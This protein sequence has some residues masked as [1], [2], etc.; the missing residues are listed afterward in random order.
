MS[1]D[2]T[3]ASVET[4]F[5]KTA[6]RT[7]ERLTSDAPV[8]R[9]RETVR[10]G[11]DRMRAQILSRLPDDLTGARVLDAG[12][13]AGQMT[14]ELAARGADVVAVDISPSLVAIARKR[15]PIDLSAR[16]SFHS[17]DMLSERL[18]S[19]DH[20]VAMDSLIYYSQADIARALAWL[21]LRTDSKVVFTVAPRTPLL[22]A[23]WRMG[24]MFPRADRSP[25][26]V[27]HAAQG[28]SRA[29]AKTGT[30]A[31]LSPLSRI[32]SGFYISQAM[33]LSR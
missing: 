8:S 27:P 10:A 2:R 6:T 4:Y 20:V 14:A 22:M 29:L 12:C 25:T 32:T 11:R 26:M 7:W 31:R 33:E 30:D 17:G 13:G 18:G 28:L 21:A 1:Y 24:Q 9:I 19:F 16:V 5:D 3:L 15:L 23:M